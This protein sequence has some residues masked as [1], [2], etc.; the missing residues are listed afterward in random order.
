M[1]NVTVLTTTPVVAV[2]ITTGMLEVGAGRIGG[3]VTACFT[4]TSEDALLRMSSRWLRAIATS[5]S[6]S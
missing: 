3:A 1:M 4:G 2:K 6:R 5:F